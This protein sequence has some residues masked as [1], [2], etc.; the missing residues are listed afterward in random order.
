MHFE[1]ERGEGHIKALRDSINGLQEAKMKLS[2]DKGELKTPKERRQE[3]GEIKV[4]LDT[5][6]SLKASQ[7]FFGKRDRL[8]K[9]GWRHGVFGV[10][11]AD[12]PKDNSVFYKGLHEAKETLDRNKSLINNRR[13]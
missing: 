8:F 2:G 9:G 7:K 5:F 6:N 4:Q 3:L 11:D 10:E 13:A 12:Q 1:T